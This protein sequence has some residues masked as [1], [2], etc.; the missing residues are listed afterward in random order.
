MAISLMVTSAKMIGQESLG[1]R[2]HRSA[3]E[4]HG[5]YETGHSL[6]D[7]VIHVTQTFQ[8]DTNRVDIDQRQ[9]NH[10]PIQHK[11]IDGDSLVC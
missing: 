6:I 8:S 4:A 5:A 11:R 1:R 3:E 2:R 10:P 7:A 9:K